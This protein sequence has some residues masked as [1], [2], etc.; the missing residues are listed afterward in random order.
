MLGWLPLIA[1][2]DICKLKFLGRLIYA[3]DNLC[4]K[5]IFLRRLYHNHLRYSEQSLE[6]IPDIKS[7]FLTFLAI[8]LTTM[9]FHQSP[10]GNKLLITQCK[11][12]MPINGKR[13]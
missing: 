4:Y 10:F 7:T 3:N 2:I 8:L 5:K 12:I 1:Q 9:S 11:R 6:F 13:G